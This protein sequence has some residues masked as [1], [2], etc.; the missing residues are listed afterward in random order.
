LSENKSKEIL[1]T[2]DIVMIPNYIKNK[3]GCRVIADEDFLKGIQHLVENG[4][5]RID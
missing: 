5:I 3:T 1:F 4:V 2:N